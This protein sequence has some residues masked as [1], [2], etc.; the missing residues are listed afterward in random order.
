MTFIIENMQ[1]F[2][3]R[4]TFKH[5]YFTRCWLNQYY[6]C[7]LVLILRPFVHRAAHRMVSGTM[8]DTVNRHEGQLKMKRFVPWGVR[9]SGGTTSRPVSSWLWLSIKSCLT[10]TSVCHRRTN[11]ER[12]LVL[13]PWTT[14]TVVFESKFAFHIEERVH[15]NRVHIIQALEYKGVHW[16]KKLLSKW[17]LDRLEIEHIKHKPLVFADGHSCFP[18]R[19]LQFYWRISGPALE[20]ELEDKLSTLQQESTN[21]LMVDEGQLLPE[22]FKIASFVLFFFFQP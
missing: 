18:D 17:D 19:T 12:R 5:T 6:K 7:H 3:V 10:Q 11:C 14:T 15:P 16:K 22:G 4:P 21:K 2:Q 8:L 1:G 20:L 13:N 9:I